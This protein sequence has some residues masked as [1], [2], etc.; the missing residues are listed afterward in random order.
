MRNIEVEEL[1]EV[2]TICAQQD[3]KYFYRAIEVMFLG[4]KQSNQ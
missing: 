2:K 3:I 1:A 4:E